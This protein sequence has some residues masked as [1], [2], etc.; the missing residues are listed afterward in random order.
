MPQLENYTPY[1][2]F[3]YYSLDNRGAEF[4]VVIVKATF[5]FA[6]D[7]R[8]VSAEEQAP[9]VF[10]DL[11]HGAVNE[12]SLWHPSDLVPYKPGGEVLVNAVARA[13]EGKPAPSWLCGL[14]VEGGG[15][16]IE[17][18]LRVTGERSW[19][20]GW[21]RKLD[22]DEAADWRKHRAL[23]EGWH[24]DDPEPA[25]EVPLRWEL[26]YGGLLPRG[27][28]GDGAP[29]VEANEHNPL[30]VGWIDREATDHTRPVP[31]PRIEDPGK[32]LS[33]PYEVLSPQGFGPIPPAWLPRRPLGGT[34]DR[35]W[36]ETVWPNWPAD[37]DF[38]Y[39][40]SAPPDLRRPG[41]FTGRERISLVNLLPG[42]GERQFA[43]PGIAVEARFVRPD[44][45]GEA[46]RLSLDTIF[47]DIAA[48][49]REDRH[50][51]LVWRTRFE[52]DVFSR[53]ELSLVDASEAE[54]DG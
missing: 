54:V 8:L 6:G 37:Y 29:V 5:A 28:D 41:F 21:G 31:A 10:T 30:G 7:G 47:V 32:R 4:G 39:H 22:A 23:F 53:V 34:Y 38:A 45:S 12:T 44:R 15:H 24:L 46:R 27:V 1:P 13:P 33:D 50:V 18:T 25:L 14:R 2:N 43:L 51:L 40:Q 3:R 36:K 16:R 49:H 9:M 52:P 42:G 26:A 48:E 20:P 11:C 17:K 35:R 19:R